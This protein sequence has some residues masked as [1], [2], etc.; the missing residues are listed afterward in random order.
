MLFEAK[1]NV[2]QVM[3]YIENKERI[4][5]DKIYLMLEKID[6]KITKQL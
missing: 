2:E 5:R 6:D 1:E 4:N 3:S